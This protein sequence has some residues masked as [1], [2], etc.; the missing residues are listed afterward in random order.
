MVTCPPHYMA[1]PYQC[2]EVERELSAKIENE[3]TDLTPYEARLYFAAFEYVWRA[4]F[5]ENTVQSVRKAAQ[6]LAELAD[7]L[8][9]RGL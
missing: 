5:K 3:G 7:T 1:G 6:D 2:K 9:A 8:E 4:P